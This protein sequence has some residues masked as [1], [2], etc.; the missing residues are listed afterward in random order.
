MSFKILS[1]DGG[2]IRGI[3]TASILE[4]VERQIQQHHG[5]SLHEYFDLIAGTSTGSILTAG[6][7]TKKNSSELIKLYKEQGKT[8][9]PIHRKERYQPIPSPLPQFIEVVSPPKYLHQG[10]TKVLKNVLGDS[11]IKDVESPIIL[12][13]AYDTLY[14]NTTFFTNCHPDIGDR[15]YDDCY[16]WEICAASAS[17]PT[18]FPPYKLEPVNKEKYGNWV[19][20]H[21]DGGVAANNPALAALSLVMRLSQS[22]ISPEIKQKYNLDSIK[23]L[24]DIAI[25]SIGT[26]QTGE[27]YEF[28]QIKDWRGVNWAQHLVD[29]FMEPTSEVSSTICRHLMGGYN[30]QR[31]LR[32]QFDLNEKFMVKKDETY[33]DT[34]ELLNSKERVNKFTKTRLSEEMDDTREETLQSLID[35]TSKFIEY[36][37][38]FQTRNECGSQVKEAITAFIQAN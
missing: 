31:Y 6:I 28:E 12:I 32:L 34:R 18:Y 36:G 23:S 33:K 17:A 27:P 13:L 19:F 16:L 26:G 9:F 22:S 8:I 30:S 7:S 38:A 14:R 29:I 1:L 2:G 11:R 5:K 25:L 3:I 24:E 20:P 35:A 4:E 15:W 37:Y 21:I 10:L